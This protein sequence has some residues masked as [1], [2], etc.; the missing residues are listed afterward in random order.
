LHLEK[1]KYANVRNVIFG[2]QRYRCLRIRCVRVG[3]VLIFFCRGLQQKSRAEEKD[4]QK[5]TCCRS[6]AQQPLPT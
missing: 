1:K 2:R 6:G 5:A 4:E 3:C